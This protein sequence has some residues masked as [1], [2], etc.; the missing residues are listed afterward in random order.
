[1]GTTPPRYQIGF[2][3][4]F[5]DWWRAE[6]P[7]FPGS[8]ALH[9]AAESNRPEAS[10]RAVARMLVIH[11]AAD[12]IGDKREIKVDAGAAAGYV[13]ALVPV[14]HPEAGALF[15]CISALQRHDMAAL[16]TALLSAAFVCAAQSENYS[17]RSM[18]HLS[19]K[20]ALEVGAWEDALRA[21]RLLERV[22]IMDENPVAAR[23]WAARADIQR[24]NAL[25]E[26]VTEEH[27]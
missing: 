16:S 26:D 23:R 15:A 19:Y 13:V 24:K 2:M 27:H 9:D 10:A 25:H 14:D 12:V 21:A 8:A 4:Q 3:I 11:A 22:A 7:G 20:A 17:A 5:I 6:R 18:A 1:M